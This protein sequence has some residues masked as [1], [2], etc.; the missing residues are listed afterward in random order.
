[1][2]TAPFPQPVRPLPVAPVRRTPTALP[3]DAGRV[4]L[5]IRRI[6]NTH[7]GRTLQMLG[8]AAEHLVYSRGFLES[9][10]SVADDEAVRILMRLSSAVFREYADSR[11]VR[12]P[13]EDFVMGCANWLLE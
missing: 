8:H 1:M 4:N 12:R 9:P 2:S 6:S 5:T 13:V 7:H 10:P 11:R 3:L